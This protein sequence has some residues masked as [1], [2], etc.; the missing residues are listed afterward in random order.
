MPTMQRKSEMTS[1]SKAVM[2]RVTLYDEDDDNW[3][4]FQIGTSNDLKMLKH[5]MLYIRK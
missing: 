1:I 5:C 2:M 3:L 4:K